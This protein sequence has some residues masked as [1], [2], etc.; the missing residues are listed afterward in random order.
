MPNATVRANARTLP[1]ATS[2]RAVLGAVLAAGAAGATAALPAEAAAAP[3]LSAA[4]EHVLELWRRLADL[5]AIAE[6]C[7][8]LYYAARDQLPEWAAPGPK[9]CRPD[10]S[11]GDTE[12]TSGWPMVACLDRRPINDRGQINAR[13]DPDDLRIELLLALQKGGDGAGVLQEYSQTFAEVSARRRQ[14]IEE[15]RRLNIDAL[16][17]RAAAADQAVGEVETE[18]QSYMG[19]SSLAVAA[20]L[21]V[22][23]NE[24][25]VEGLNRAALRA[26]RPQLVGEIGEEADRVLAEAAEEEAAR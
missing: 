14:Q 23:L 24:E 17:E 12:M 13:P 21:M 25:E 9:Y 10:G 22:S 19:E 8:E 1:E 7:G 3:A 4:D 18:F 20:V 26:I 11:P 2:R 15:I 16:C 5:R 6:R